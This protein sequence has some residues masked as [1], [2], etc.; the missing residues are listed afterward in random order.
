MAK[1]GFNF[2]DAV[3]KL[4]KYSK[5]N[6]SH[7]KKT[8]F[9]AGKLIPLTWWEGLPG[10]RF[11]VDVSAL[12]KTFALEAPMMHRESLTIRLFKVP[13]SKILNFDDYQQAFTGGE[14]GEH[15]PMP[16]V[17]IMTEYCTV[18]SLM[19]YLG[20][21][22][23]YKYVNGK[24]EFAA[25]EVDE[26]KGYFN[27]VSIL[28]FLAYHRI[29]NDYYRN[30][31]TQRPVSESKT[32]ELS[33]N[34]RF[35]L[36]DNYDTEQVFVDSNGQ[37]IYPLHHLHNVGW[38]RDY[39]TSALKSSQRGDQITLPTAVLPEQ[40]INA[41]GYYTVESSS[42]GNN[43]QTIHPIG[44]SYNALG[45]G[46]QPLKVGGDLMNSQKGIGITIPRQELGTIGAIALR[47]AMNLQALLEKF[48]ISGY[49]LSEQDAAL[50]GTKIKDS[51]TCDLI[52]GVKIPVTVSEVTQTSESSSTPLG[53]LGG[54]SSAVGSSKLG[55]IYCE[56]RC[57][58]MV[59]ASLVPRTGYSQGL[60]RKWTRRDYLD[61]YIP[62]LQTIGEQEIKNQEVYL[63]FWGRTNNDDTWAYQS[64]YSEYKYI[65][66]SITG[67]FRTSLD[68]WHKSRLFNQLPNF[69]DNFVSCVPTD[70][71]FAVSDEV[72]EQHYL[73]WFYF[74][75]QAVRPMAKF[76]TSK[77][78]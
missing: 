59:C 8:T 47:M 78:W 4:P 44:G 14:N 75:V 55:K 16:F 20:L 38:E 7:D 54:K 11:T 42:T 73:G 46:S 29:Y 70:R 50:F 19:D 35:S 24:W 5:F 74:N 15:I 6:L 60:E 61:Y 56:E 57:I 72:S 39:F 45:V 12:I 1:R 17:H 66:D 23:P 10:D 26:T 51:T 68:F 43:V 40:R 28:P 30:E 3:F 9:N 67:D 2:N 13:L 49:R 34:T 62:E 37:G 36:L 77:L 65:P 41:D 48:N 27:E 18:G 25:D 71:T 64:R 63:D 76:N 69:N 22:L 58:I 21:P 31:E 52:G 53:H 32:D 33:F